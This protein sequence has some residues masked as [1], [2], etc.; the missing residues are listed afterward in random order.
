MAAMYDV[1][2]RKVTEVRRG[3]SRKVEFD[4]SD[5]RRTKR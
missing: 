3:Q 2:A 5:R 4:S 1:M